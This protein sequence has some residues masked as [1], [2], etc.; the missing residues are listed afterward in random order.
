MRECPHQG[1]IIVLNTETDKI[2]TGRLTNEA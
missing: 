1:E 2:E